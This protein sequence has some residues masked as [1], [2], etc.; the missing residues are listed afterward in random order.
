MGKRIIQRRRGRGGPA[1]KSPGHRFTDDARYAPLDE[2]KKGGIMQVLDF[3][4]DRAHSA[5]FALMITET[6]ENRYHLA[7]Q[8]LK[9]G[10]IIEFGEEAKV[11]VGNMLP[12][13]KIP[14][15]TAIHNIETVPGDGGKLVRTS[16]GSG[17]VVTHDQNKKRTVVRLPSRGRIELDF[18]CRATIGVLAGGGRKEKPFVKA[19]SKSK[20]M[21]ARNKLYPKT[22]AVAMNAVD[23]PF[24]GRT[25]PGRTTSA[26]RHAPPGAKVGNLWPRRTGVRRTKQL[27]EEKTS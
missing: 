19:G 14:E 3:I 4:H 27:T 16:G 6:F 7:P 26:G 1:Y 5:P 12:L 8:G 20:A 17:F 25:K 23:H 21:E 10:D 22:S 2:F 13:G 9:V 24:G 18:E 11:A 15:G